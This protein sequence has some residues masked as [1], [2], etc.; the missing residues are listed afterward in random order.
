M[1]LYPVSQR[2]MFRRPIESLERRVLLAAHVVVNEIMYH[3]S[4]HNPADEWLEL[5]NAGDAP[6]DMSGW[7]FS[8][9]IKYTFAGGTTLGAGQY[10][11][12]ARDLS[13]FQAK[14]PSVA[15][16][17]GGW[18]GGLSNH[19]DTLRLDDT[20]GAVQNEL[21]YGS[22]GD[23]AQR[24]LGPLDNNHRGWIWTTPADGGGRSI[25][26]INP[27]LDNG[28]GQNW[29]PSLVDQGTPGAANSVRSS[30]S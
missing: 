16:V 24:R 30:D 17:V 29:A 23:W 13:R 10:L 9:G 3:A 28:S 12:L 6:A 19:G 27:A 15:N 4:G 22:E 11:V 2:R 7:Q 20:A 21:T 14:Y 25:E 26:L 18:Q 5:Y 1:S 8:K